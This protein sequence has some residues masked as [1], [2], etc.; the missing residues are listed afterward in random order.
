MF[1]YNSSSVASWMP[2]D[3]YDARADKSG[4]KHDC[5][6]PLRWYIGTHQPFVML[7]N[8]DKN[9][10]EISRL[11]FVWTRQPARRPRS[12]WFKSAP[13]IS[14]TGVGLESVFSQ[15][16]LK[17]PHDNRK[18]AHWCG[19]R[20]IEHGQHHIFP[21]LHGPRAFWNGRVRQQKRAARSQHFRWSNSNCSIFGQPPNRALVFI[22]LHD[23][24]TVRVFGFCVGMPP[25]AYD[26]TFEWSGRAVW[27]CRN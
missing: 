4:R 17:A 21:L 23:G 6:I 2:R 5:Q 13:V 26:V 15:P 16:F 8:V 24:H 14:E 7:K 25:R 9:G 18:L 27:K 12:N 10:G 19:C 22:C 11:L 20:S 1:V 3:W